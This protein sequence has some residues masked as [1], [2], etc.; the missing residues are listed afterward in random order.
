MGYFNHS[1]DTAVL[2]NDKV[3]KDFLLTVQERALSSSSSFFL[4]SKT[5]TTVFYLVNSIKKGIYRICKSLWCFLSR[6]IWIVLT[7]LVQFYRD[8][9]QNLLSSFGNTE[10]ISIFHVV[11]KGPKN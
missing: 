6:F 4:T 2:L 5:Q 10:Q 9:P 1:S 3:K 7:L 11:L 8:H